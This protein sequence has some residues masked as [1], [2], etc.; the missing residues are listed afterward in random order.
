MPDDDLEQAVPRPKAW[1]P[2]LMAAANAIPVTMPGSVIG[3]T[4]R[5]EIVL[6]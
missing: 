2:K 3:S 5:N 1:P 6:R 4:S